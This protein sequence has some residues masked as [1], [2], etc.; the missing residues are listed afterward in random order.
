MKAGQTAQFGTTLRSL[1]TRSRL[2]WMDHDGLWDEAEFG[3][4][5]VNLT[6][7][8]VFLP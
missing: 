3:A 8:R 5:P 7:L 6:G 1:A 4:P 2:N